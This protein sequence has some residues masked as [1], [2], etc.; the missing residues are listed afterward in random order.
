MATFSVSDEVKEDG[1]SFCLKLSMRH[2]RIVGQDPG[3]M[4]EW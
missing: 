4:G 3:G 1:L 2:L